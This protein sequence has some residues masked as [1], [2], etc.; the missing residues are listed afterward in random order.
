VKLCI[1][2]GNTQ[3]FLG[4]YRNQELIAQFRYNTASGSSSDQFG[5]FLKS[6]LKE[7]DIETKEIDSV[8]VASVVPDMD[9]SI[10][11]ACIK[12]LNKI[13]K[14][15]N[16]ESKTDI[17][18][19]YK[20][21]SELGADRIANTIGA[22]NIFPEQNLIIIDFGT[23]TT[24]CAVTKHK[25]YLGGA[26]IPGLKTSAKAL[27]LATAKLPLVEI[28]RPALDITTSTKHSIQTGIYYGQLGAVKELVNRFKEK[29]F[30]TH[31]CVVI[32]T[33]GFA[34]LFQDEQLFNVHVPDLVLKG[35][36]YYI[37]NE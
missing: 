18:L 27:S 14:F 23:A 34:Y 4:L 20:I 37:N 13:P 32:A 3:I 1:D 7:H 28:K 31:E 8:G 2:I 19:H 22:V 6:I 9:Y 12:Y 11:S 25:E 21:P 10:R 30:A 33:G 26:I 36:N 17:T 15:L 16:A 35:I 29:F 24:V 5:L